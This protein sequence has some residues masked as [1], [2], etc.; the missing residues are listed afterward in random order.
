MCMPKA[1]K[2]PPTP[3]A[4]PAAPPPTKTAK[5]AENKTLKKKNQSK[6]T[7]TSALTVKR[8]SINVSSSGTGANISY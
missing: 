6:S 4:P 8:P 1:P 3:V 2:I 7:G 5:V